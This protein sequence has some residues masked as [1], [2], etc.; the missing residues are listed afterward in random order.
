MD[1]I[2]MAEKKRK[3][4]QQYRAATASVDPAQE[5]DRNIYTHQPYAGYK[6][7]DKIIAGT[8]A[9][10][11][12]AG[13]VGVVGA[14]TYNHF[15][16][17][18]YEPNDKSVTGD[19]DTDKETSE[20][21]EFVLNE[22]FYINDSEVE[23]AKKQGNKTVVTVDEVV[24]DIKNNVD[25]NE[26]KSYVE[27]GT[28]REQDDINLNGMINYYNGTIEKSDYMSNAAEGIYRETQ[29]YLVAPYSMF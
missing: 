3:S 6:K 23:Q 9:G 1:K 8:V 2:K 20:S 13:A 4:G 16:D 24:K 22:E 29:A 25:L 11:L 14:A 19:Q 15:K 26:V 17:K 7:S 12:V 21:L 27:K 5:A 10:M 28:N 18:V